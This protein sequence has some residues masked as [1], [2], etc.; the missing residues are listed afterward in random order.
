[1]SKKLVIPYTSAFKGGSKGPDRLAVKRALRHADMLHKKGQLSEVFGPQAVHALKKYQ[2]RVSVKKGIGT[3]TRPTHDALVINREFDAYG[4]HLM[5]LAHRGSAAEQKRATIVASAM[6]AYSHAPRD[7]VNTDARRCQGYY[8]RIKPPQMWRYADCSGFALWCLWLA[9]VT[10]CG[11][12]DGWTG[13]MQQHGK[14]VS[15][16]QAKPSAMVFYNNHVAVYVGSG[17]VVSMGHD[18]GPFLVSANYRSDI[19]E[20]REYV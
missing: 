1:M 16:S 19:V 4:A 10:D 6:F 7:Y 14:R 12:Y 20:V 3:Y 13:S 15:L 18:G 2:H 9:G 17:R 8:D 11:P 5:Q